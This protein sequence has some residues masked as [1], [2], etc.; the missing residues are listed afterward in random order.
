MPYLTPQS[1]PEGGDCR[2]LF[3]PD[4]TEWLALFGGALTELTKTWN[5]EYSGGLTVN[6]TVSKMMEI[7]NDWYADACGCEVPGGFRVIRIGANGHPEMLGDDGEWTEPTGDYV[8]PA[9][10]A[11]EGGTEADQ[12]CLAAKNAVNVLEQLYENLSES[13]ADDLSEAEA[14]T[15]LIALLIALVGFEFAPIA[16]AIATFL[17]VIFGLLYRALGYL[18]ADLWTEDVS[19]QITCFL[20]D[21]ATNTA[22][23]VTFDWDC[24]T[25]HLNSLTNDFLLSETQLRLYLQISYLLNF[26]GGVDGLNLAGATTE[27]TNDDCSFCDDTW[28]YEWDQSAFESEWTFDFGSSNGHWFVDAHILVDDFPTTF[29]FISCEMDV[30]GDDVG[31]QKI[32]FWKYDYSS[33]IQTFDIVAGTN[34]FV[35]SATIPNLPGIAISGAPT[36]GSSGSITVTRVLLRGTGAN[37][38]GSDNCE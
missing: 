9:P 6:E 26:I 32:G 27:I 22:G 35:T 1:L 29:P 24:F 7:I 34:E 25:N 36:T 37:P 16:F 30:T 18:T 13:F 10:A 19:K 31:D 5:W 21:C 4:D 38:F 11:R 2:P 17:I 14:L 33:S 23:V 12:I 3:I 28:C 20:T 8:I 15:E